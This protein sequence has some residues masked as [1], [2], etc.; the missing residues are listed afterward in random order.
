M[1]LINIIKSFTSIKN[2]LNLYLFFAYLYFLLK[3]MSTFS[4]TLLVTSVSTIGETRKT[5]RALRN[6]YT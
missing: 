6:E 2:S 3:M 1:H 4:V 5:W